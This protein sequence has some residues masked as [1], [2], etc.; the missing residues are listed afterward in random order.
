M[1]RKYRP[2]EP[3]HKY[4][5]LHRWMMRTE[6]WCDLDPVARCA[7]IELSGRYG[8]PGS[9]NGRIPCSLRELADVLHVSKATAMRAVDR[10]QD[11]G[12]IVL[13]KRGNFNFK[14]KHAAEWR[15][16][17][18]GCDVTG[19]LATKDFTLWRKQ[20]AVS[21]E[22]PLGCRDETARVS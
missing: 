3:S 16:T 17:E 21:P 1:A 14:L 6:A 15:L 18:F 8:G 22:N 11:H 19:E 2:P 20:T 12:F 4:V 10:L 5:L 7:Y 9:N 13:M